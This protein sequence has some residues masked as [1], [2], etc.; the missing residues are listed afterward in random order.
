MADIIY[1]IGISILILF[2]W[3]FH[4]I[5]FY[6]GL[7][8]QLLAGKANGRMI[9]IQQILLV[10]AMIVGALVLAH[11]AQGGAAE[12][13]QRLVVVGLRVALRGSEVVR[14]VD[15]LSVRVAVVRS[16]GRRDSQSLREDS[17]EVLDSAPMPE[18]LNVP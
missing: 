11:F 7:W 12:Q 3:N 17:S 8:F 14:Q 13:D 16:F 5:K 1:D 9:A 15:S 10:L 2:K 4:I 6:I 18:K